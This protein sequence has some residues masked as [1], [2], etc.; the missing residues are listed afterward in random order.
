[1]DQHNRSEIDAKNRRLVDLEAMLPAPLCVEFSQL[2]VSETA[3]MPPVSR[4]PDRTSHIL[5]L[6]EGSTHDSQQSKTR[7]HAVQTRC[8]ELMGEVEA[9][10][11]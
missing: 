3:S 5:V 7:G 1:M 6:D 2:T 11:P 10:H 4:A 9:R 8:R